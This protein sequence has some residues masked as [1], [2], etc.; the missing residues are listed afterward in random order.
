MNS[1]RQDELKISETAPKKHDRFF[2]CHAH[3]FTMDHVPDYF[4]GRFMPVTKLLRKKWV[5]NVVKN[6]PV[7][8]KMPFGLRALI[9]LLSL[10]NLLSVKK[11][12]R[13]ISMVRF[14]NSDEQRAVIESMRQYYPEDTGI[15]YLT[16]DMEYMGAGKPVKKLEKQ[17]EELAAL[18]K[19]AEYKNIIYPFAFVD[20]RR[21]DPRDEEIQVEADF[22][23]AKFLHKLEDYVKEGS[24]QGLKIYPALGYYPFDERMKPAYDLALKYNLPIT[25]HCTIGVVHHKHKIDVSK[26]IH[27]FKGTL[28]DLKPVKYQRYFSHPLNYLC[29]VDRDLLKQVWGDSAPDYRNLKIC[30]GHWGTEDDWHRYLDKDWADVYQKTKD[31]HCPALLLKN[32]HTDPKRAY[33][34]F[35]W[36]TI[37]YELLRNKKFPNLYTDISYTLHDASLLP[38]L[39][40]MLESN[41]DVRKRV[42][43]GT[44]FYMVSKTI[45]ER[46]YS[47][48]LR[49]ALGHEMFEQI[50]IVNAREFLKNNFT[51]PG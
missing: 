23:G 3:C 24:F 35:T 48:N 4:F 15:V 32:W 31:D 38:M 43:F 42:L 37:I 39:K 12:L 1:V 7:T 28:P 29:L 10:I 22:I 50:A 14:G 51:S 16:M 9:F 41:E 27:P 8:G 47:I 34:N 26:R 21:I 33:L 17:F 40:T 44:D 18:K 45:S 2:N 13:L 6:G 5:K 20:P 36:F 19:T 11:F 46:N 30:I 49:A 25:T